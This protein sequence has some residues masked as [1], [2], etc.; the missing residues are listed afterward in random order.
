MIATLAAGAL[1]G[2]IAGAVAGIGARSA[3][4]MV[5]DGVADSVGVT[6]EFTIPGTLTIVISG[7]LAGAPAGALFN[8]IADRLPGPAQLRGLLFGLILLAA[9]G[10]FFLRTEEFFSLGRVLLFVPLFPLFGIVLGLAIEPSRKLASR[11]PSP[12]RKV[13]A[14]AA[15][16]VVGLVLFSIVAAVLGLPGG[17]VM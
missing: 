14:F 12:A 8:A 15:A 5:A 13:L 1:A 16:V 2:I 4:R 11:L 6:P 9:I 17:F 10:P 7:M 3:M